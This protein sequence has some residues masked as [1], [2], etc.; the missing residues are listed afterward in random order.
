MENHT[1]PIVC[2]ANRAILIRFDGRLRIVRDAEKPMQDRAFAILSWQ[3]RAP[4]SRKH[5]R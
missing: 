1:V 2:K 4:D 5:F 3:P